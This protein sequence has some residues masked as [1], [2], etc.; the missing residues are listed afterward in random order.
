MKILIG[1]F[2]VVLLNSCSIIKENDKFGICFFIKNIYNDSDFVKSGSILP[3]PFEVRKNNYPS[4]I[5]V[6]MIN[7]I[8]SN[9]L[10]KQ[11]APFLP[12]NLNLVKIDDF[13]DDLIK[14]EEEKIIV[15]EPNKLPDNNKINYLGYL[16]ILQVYIDTSGKKVYIHYTKT[17]GNEKGY[18]RCYSEIHLIKNKWKEIKSD[19]LDMN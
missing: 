18:F 16:T 3:E 15:I 14:L 2:A 6:K 12:T 11:I 7:P 9:E 4:V 19:V 5:I 1:L 17:N 13:K 10:H 8:Y